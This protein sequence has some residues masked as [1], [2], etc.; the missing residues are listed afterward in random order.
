MDRL[1]RT[2]ARQQRL[3]E[4]AGAAP[5]TTARRRRRRAAQC[6]APDVPV[7]G[8]RASVDADR[9]SARSARGGPESSIQP[10]PRTLISRSC[11][12]ASIGVAVVV[13]MT[14]PDTGERITKVVA[15]PKARMSVL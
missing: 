6:S 15:G 7:A 1:K 8:A 14:H 11:Q 12:K 4:K 9:E 13:V 10:F 2:L 3:L 5:S